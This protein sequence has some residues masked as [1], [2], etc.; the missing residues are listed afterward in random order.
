LGNLILGNLTKIIEIL[1]ME[2]MIKIEKRGKREKVERKGKNG[3]SYQ[4]LQNTEGLRGQ[5][6]KKTPT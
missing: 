5:T 3:A 1:R 2:K 6:R 4:V